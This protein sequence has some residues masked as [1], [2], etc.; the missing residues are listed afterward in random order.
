MQ[1]SNK[2]F[3]ALHVSVNVLMVD[4]IK[5]FFFHHEVQTGASS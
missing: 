1:H 2:M 3:K 4:D 5:T